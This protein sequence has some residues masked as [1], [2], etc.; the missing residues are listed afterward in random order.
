MPRSVQDGRG[1]V[2]TALRRHWLGT[3]IAMAM[4]VSVVAAGYVGIG[5]VM[6]DGF[7]KVNP[8]CGTIGPRPRFSDLTPANLRYTPADFGPT[9]TAASLVLH[10]DLRPYLMP[11]YES[12]TFPSRVGAGRPPV[13]IAAWWVPGSAGNA[14]AVI[15]VHGRGSCRK[16]W[17]VA[18]PAGMLHR[19]GFSVLL[20]DLRNQG[21]STITDGRYYGGIV[22][23]LDVLGAF[24]WLTRTKGVAE[25]RVGLFGASLGAAAVLLAAADEPRLVAVWEDSGY[26]DTEQ[27]VTEELQQRAVWFPALIAPAG[28]IAGQLVG[29]V[30]I[31]GDSPLAAVRRLRGRALYIVHGAADAVT[32]P[33]HA[34][35]LLDAAREA[36]V[37]VAAWIVPYAGHTW[38]VVVDPQGYEQR[39]DAF[40][41]A[42]LTG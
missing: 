10:A 34:Q 26:A 19:A 24:D 39:L 23:A 27:R 6:F 38:E 12:V 5:V 30:D 40:F 3:V 36:G 35:E 20:L 25:G 31:Y 21:D 1:T 33:H 8:G 28:G 18:I 16:D 15:A 37:E 7:S 13:A 9:D 41:R 4:I 14:P 32:P 42:H 17:N 22:E 11:D 29:G 2:M